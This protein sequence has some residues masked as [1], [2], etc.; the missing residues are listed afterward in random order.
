M[1]KSIGSEEHQIFL[2]NDLYK[3][4]IHNALQEHCSI[5][6][7]KRVCK[8]FNEIINNKETQNL[9]QREYTKN[10]TWY[11]LTNP[12]APHLTT[13]KKNPHILFLS[14]D[15]G[16]PEFFSNLEAMGV[17]NKINI[18]TSLQNVIR[19]L[20]DIPHLKRLLL[21]GPVS[22]ESLLPR[23]ANHAFSIQVHTV[24]PSD[25]PIKM[26]GMPQ[27]SY[28]KTLKELRLSEPLAGN[29]APY[30]MEQMLPLLPNLKVIISPVKD[31]AASSV[32]ETPALI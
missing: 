14:I 32:V 31:Q 18:Q 22:A 24:K 16:N 17:K 30:F 9:I 8:K 12:A 15:L 3:P 4:I 20:K 25:D 19:V 26:L 10:V 13:L 28:L 6:N 7:I 5:E 11:D 29:L 21:K 1:E 27:L 2:P 23:T